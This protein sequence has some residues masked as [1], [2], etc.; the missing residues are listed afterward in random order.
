LGLPKGVRE[1]ALEQPVEGLEEGAVQA[2]FTFDGDDFDMSGTPLEIVVRQI[3]YL[4]ASPYKWFEREGWLVLG[5]GA[6]NDNVDRILALSP[7]QDGQRSLYGLAKNGT[8]HWQIRLQETGSLDELG[9]LARAKAEQYGNTALMIKG[10]AWH[11]QSATDGQI[12][13]L[14]RL[15]P[16]GSLKQPYSLTKAQAADLI[17]YYQTRQTLRREGVL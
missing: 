5:L 14:K 13:F 1:K 7:D 4:N 12:R 8:P 15:A 11:N 9:D 16:E 6:G 3:D 17:T 2:G 10:R